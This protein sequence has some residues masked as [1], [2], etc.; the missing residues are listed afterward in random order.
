MSMSCTICL[1]I[2]IFPPSDLNS[3]HF[4]YLRT[5]TLQVQHQ[6]VIVK[7]VTKTALQR[8]GDCSWFRV[9]ETECTTFGKLL[10]ADD[11]I[12]NTDRSQ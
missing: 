8:G 3:F 2:Y 1:L 5:M 10:H 6:K 12:V 11:K 9:E 4:V 7:W